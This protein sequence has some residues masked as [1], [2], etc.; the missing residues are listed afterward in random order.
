MLMIFG[1]IF[2]AKSGF[3]VKDRQLYYI[4]VMTYIMWKLLQKSE[5]NTDGKLSLPKSF[6]ILKLHSELAYCKGDRCDGQMYENLLFQN[7]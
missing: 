7:L 4:N 6:K 1:A 2:G 5:R 3:A